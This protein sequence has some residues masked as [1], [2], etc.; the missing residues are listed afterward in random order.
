MTS[1]TLLQDKVCIITGA[2]KGIGRDCAR[3]FAEHGAKLALIS[4]TEDDLNELTRQLDLNENRI[5]CMAGDA[6]DESTVNE[7]VDR[8]INQFGKIDVL[9]NNAGIRFRK[10]FTDI[11]WDEWQK[12]MTVNTGSTFLFCKAVG[13]HMLQRQS[14]KIVNMASI[15]GSNGLPELAG[16]GA[17]KGAIITLTKCIA[18]EWAESGVN[19]NVI[20]PGFC[21]TSY[22][23]SFKKK[24]DLYNFTIERTP[25]RKWGS[26]TDVANACLYLSS[27]MSDYVTGTTLHVDGGWDAW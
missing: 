12:V 18:A 14:G 7:F 4:R 5:L 2:G 26:G 15:I 17:S 27:S 16:Y 25:M 23:E 3:V 19:V 6:S 1:T 24:S 10:A 8:V 9:I 21:E 22:A 11:S 20:A 13:T